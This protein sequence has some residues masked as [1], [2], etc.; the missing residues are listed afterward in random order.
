MPFFHL[1]ARDSSR[2]RLA[3]ASFDW[4]QRPFNLLV[5]TYV[6][7]PFFA[8]ALAPDPV[9]G[10]T[11]WGLALGGAGFIVAMASPAIGAISD[12]GGRKKPWIAAFGML[13]VLGASLL[14]FAAPGGRWSMAI[15]IAG[16]AI[17]VI[18]S[19]FAIVFHNS[20]MPSLALAGRIGRL[21]GM[22]WATGSLG[23]LVALLVML[24]FVLAN[25]QTGR[26]MVG[27][28]P[29]IP[30]DPTMHEGERLVGPFAAAWFA[31]F[32][33][34]MFVAMPDDPASALSVRTAV[35]AGLRAYRETMRGFPKRRDLTIFLLANM[36]YTDGLGA[37]FAFGGI[38][39]AAIFGWGAAQ[40]TLLAIALI[41]LTAI[42]AFAV[43]RLIDRSGS[44]RII[45]ANV[46][47]L[48]V[49]TVGILGA[50]RDTVLF[51]IPVAPPTTDG[52]LFGSIG[53]KSFLAFAALIGLSAGPLQAA[54]RSHL[55][56]LAPP[57]KAA[58]Y[59]GFFALSGRLTAFVGPT[60]VGV[61]TAA[62]ASQRLG[63]APIALML[64]I[65][66][67]LVATLRGG[68]AGS[69]SRPG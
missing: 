33:T 21:S 20:L 23:G 22:A 24:L 61:I 1:A 17:A 60:L 15:A 25:P 55:A 46:G 37:I 35:R 34:P 30:L 36:A 27:L 47:A 62:T 57:G 13:L 14:W 2:A 56:L 65:G 5:L 18:G 12:A 31:L 3:W 43:G 39:A 42:A 41:S 9:K 52:G 49:A 28:A 8:S 48:L 50:T 26:T 69:A 68:E 4:A 63:L 16:V 10:Q 29:A 19:E 67:V 66:L 45:M 6:F 64:A 7:A 44:K 40:L 58:Q 53:E 54:S 59:F 51:V 38:Y 11:I 32:V